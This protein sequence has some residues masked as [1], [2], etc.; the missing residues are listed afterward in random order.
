[1]VTE[2]IRQQTWEEDDLDHELDHVLYAVAQL[3]KPAGYGG[4]NEQK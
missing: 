1:M 2:G 3:E 4:I